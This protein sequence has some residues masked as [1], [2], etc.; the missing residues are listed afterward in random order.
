MRQFLFRDLPNFFKN[1]YRFRKALWNHHWW[2]YH[3]TLL[4]MQIGV[5]DIS[6]NLEKKG[7]EVEISRLKKVAKMRRAS[8]IIQNIT[9]DR[10]FDIVEIEM[11]RAYDSSGID[12]V[13]APAISSGKIE[14]KPELYELVDNNSVEQKEF[15]K[16][17]L[18][19]VRELEELEWNELWTI[20]KGQDYKKFSKEKDWD[21][22]FDG[23]GMRGWWD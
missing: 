22:Q 15:N 19:R 10:Y 8:E 21:D 6:K 5:D 1:I 23:S 7:I 3:G 12:F 18:E 2:D 20:L 11:G 16:K 9:E 4:F 17:F 14:D 13:T